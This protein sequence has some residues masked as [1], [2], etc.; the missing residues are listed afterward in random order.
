MQN[1]II[2]EKL[3]RMAKWQIDSFLKYKF[4]LFYTELFGIIPLY[5]DQRD[6]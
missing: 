1:K 5:L 6:L 4:C 2:V 3:A